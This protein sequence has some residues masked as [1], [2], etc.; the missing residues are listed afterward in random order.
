MLKIEQRRIAH[1][2]TKGRAGHKPRAIVIHIMSGYYNGTD[3]W[4]HN[5]ASGA[6]THYGVSRKGQVRQW[7]GELDSAWHC[8]TLIKPTWKL[9]DP[10]VDPKFE[11]IGIEHEGFQT[12]VWTPEMKAASAELIANIARRWKFPLDR[13]H[14]IG[15]Y[16]LSGGRRDNC[17]SQG[18]NANHIIEELIELAKKF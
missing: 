5:P 12:D 3:A 1:N 11:T 2:Y 7:V 10:R 14:V 6:S 13:D 16:Q 15:H 17:P 9:I 4:F 8:G 18:R